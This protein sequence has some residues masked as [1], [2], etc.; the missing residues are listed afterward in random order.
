MDN[1]W[2]WRKAITN[3]TARKETNGVAIGIFIPKKN[4]NARDK[5]FFNDWKEKEKK[6]LESIF[7]E[8]R[9][10]YLRS[11]IKYDH[12]EINDDFFFNIRRYPTETKMHN[13]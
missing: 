12:R 9:P 5:S 1:L 7:I 3:E 13:A 6:Q 10:E 4:N 2:I 11:S 8:F